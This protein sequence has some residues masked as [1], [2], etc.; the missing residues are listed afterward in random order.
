MSFINVPRVK[1]E[2]YVPHVKVEPV[3]LSNN[4]SATI[5]VFSTSIFRQENIF[6]PLLLSSSEYN[7][8]PEGTSPVNV[9]EQGPLFYT[10]PSPPSSVSPTVDSTLTTPLVS[11]TAI[12]LLQ[13]GKNTFATFQLRRE[14]WNTSKHL[15]NLLRWVHVVF[16][17]VIE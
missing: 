8:S 1:D 15:L 12:S 16:L 14:Y 9:T 11:N 5:D 13:L 17:V 10:Q 3:N 7:S 2:Q 4:K 6:F